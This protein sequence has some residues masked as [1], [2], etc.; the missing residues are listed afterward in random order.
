MNE[1][2]NAYAMNEMSGEDT[3]GDGHGDVLL[4]PPEKARTHAMRRAPPRAHQ[5]RDR[6]AQFHPFSFSLLVP[7]L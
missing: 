1:V 4:V 3:A 7:M 2:N 6:R 5:T